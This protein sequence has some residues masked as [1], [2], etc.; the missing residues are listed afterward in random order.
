MNLLSLRLP[1]KTSLPPV[2]ESELMAYCFETLTLIENLRQ[3]LE[4]YGAEG[5]PHEVP[6]W[7]GN[8]QQLAIMKASRVWLVFKEL[9]SY[10]ELGKP[11]NISSSENIG[12]W[13]TDHLENAVKWI[14]CTYPMKEY[15]GF[16]LSFVGEQ[17][18]YK[19]LARLKL[20][21]ECDLE[22]VIGC[23]LTPF[24]YTHEMHLTVMEIALLAG[25]SERS[26]RN[27]IY[28]K[29]DRLEHIKDGRQVYV[30]V[31][32]ARRW[33]QERRKFTRTEGVAY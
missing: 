29:D 10:A 23:G 31:K 18:V 28:S 26:V 25:I 6:K 19:F 13:L 8:K 5:D 27:A 2:Q 14:C 17:I 20:D 4:S 22:E 30:S 33:L 24:P 7:E 32:E 3:S 21:F 1:T 15:H 16:Y 11:I 12:A 9:F